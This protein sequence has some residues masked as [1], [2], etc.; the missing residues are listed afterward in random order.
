MDYPTLSLR[1]R[2]LRWAQTRA[3][4]KERGLDCLIVAGLRGSY[5]NR[6]DIYLAYEEAVG[7]LIFPLEDEPTYLAWNGS[8]IGRHVTNI[9]RGFACWVKDW[10]IGT[11]GESWVRLLKERGFESATIGV[12]GVDSRGPMEPEGIVPYQTW[13][14]VQKGLPKATFV[15][16]SYPFAEMISGPKSEESIAMY[17]H[18]AQISEKVCGLVIDMLKPGVRENDIYAEMMATIFRHGAA[19]DIGPLFR[20]AQNSESVSNAPPSWLIQG[21]PPYIVQRGDVLFSE[22]FIIYAGLETQT[23]LCVAVDPVS[24]QTREC[25]KVARDTYEAGLNALRPG[26]TFGEVADAMEKVV[27]D[28]G[29]WH[30]GPL[31]HSLN[32]HTNTIPGNVGANAWGQAHGVKWPMD[33]VGPYLARVSDAKSIIKPWTCFVLEPNACKGDVRVNLG[34]CVLVTENGVEEVNK[35]ATELHV[36]Y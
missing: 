23:Q 2:D 34:G 21:Q 29:C 33:M 24:R 10:R 8:Y 35:L 26:K 25:A 31:V 17:R 7:A 32:P 1:E 20:I 22:I 27:A 9:K 16:V 19:A 14:S 30:M 18:C 36:V 6:Y 13:V 5:Q 12:V 4:M 11:K 28:A 3:F 15:H